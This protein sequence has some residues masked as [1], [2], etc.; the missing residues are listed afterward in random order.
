MCSDIRSVFLLQASPLGDCQ[1]PL[2]VG[3]YTLHRTFRHMP[4]K[5]RPKTVK[6]HCSTYYFSH[7]RSEVSTLRVGVWWFKVA[8]WMAVLIVGFPS[9]D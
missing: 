6:I 1:H 4:F 3:F 9:S 7:L 2:N 5:Q 8:L